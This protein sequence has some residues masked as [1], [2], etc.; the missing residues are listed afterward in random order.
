MA[1]QKWFQQVTERTVRP[2]WLY[3]IQLMSRRLTEIRWPSTANFR[4]V[5]LHQS[6]FTNSHHNNAC[7]IIWDISTC[8]TWLEVGCSV[9]R[10]QLG[11]VVVAWPRQAQL[12]WTVLQAVQQPQLRPSHAA[13]PQSAQLDVRNAA[14]A[15][16][17]MTVRLLLMTA[18]DEFAQMSAEQR[19]HRRGMDH[20][21]AVDYT[22]INNIQ[23][24]HN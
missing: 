22:N 4:A 24:K 1:R 17:L 11:L 7:I 21:L 19:L 14:V 20:C 12:Q 8:R 10:V 15:D 5:C 2:L 6:H 13:L 23:L 16:W 18:T 9:Q 3:V